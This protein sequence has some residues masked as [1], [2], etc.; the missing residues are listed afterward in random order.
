MAMEA[1]D[2][3]P[4]P[5][6]VQH[7]WLVG[8]H[9]QHNQLQ[10][11]TMLML[12]SYGGLRSATAPG[13]FMVDQCMQQRRRHHGNHKYRQHHKSETLPTEIYSFHALPR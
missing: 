8:L 10:R 9:G 11:G 3:Q 1:S 6:T 7:E 13:F 12:R 2:A 4:V 5:D